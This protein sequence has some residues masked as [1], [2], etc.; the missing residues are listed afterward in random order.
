MED[1]ILGAFVLGAQNAA[2]SAMLAQLMVEIWPSFTP[3]GVVWDGV[4]A[5]EAATKGDWKGAAIAILLG[6]ALNLAGKTRA[7]RAVARGASVAAT[8]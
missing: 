6:P 1:V 4:A 7:F 5:L 3:W 8:R 2:G